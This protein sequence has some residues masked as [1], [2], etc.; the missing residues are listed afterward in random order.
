MEEKNNQQQEE[1]ELIRETIKTRPINRKKLFRRTVITA[2]MAVIF[3]VLACITFLVLEPVFSNLLSPKEEQP[4]PEVVE[5][6]LEE[7]E[8]LPQD[9]IL[10]EETPSQSP[11]IIKEVGDTT[12]SIERYSRLYTEMYDI[13]RNVKR[14]IVTVTGV[15]EDT[16]W[17][18]NTYERKGQT[19]GMIVA[20]NSIEQLILTDYATISNSE[21]IRVTYFNDLTVEATIKGSDK[22]TGLAIVAVKNSILPSTLLD[23]K[24]IANLGSSRSSS[25]LGLPII[26]VGRPLGNIDSIEYGMITSKSSVLNMVDNNYELMTTDLHGNASSTGVIYNL[27]SEVVGII[28][29]KGPADS[30]IISVLGISDIKKTIERMSNGK[31]RAYL[32]VIGTDVTAYAASQGIPQG[33]YVTSVE[34]NSPALKAGIQ[35]GDVITQV[36]SYEISTYSNFTEAITVHEPEEEASITVRR[37]GVDGYRDVTITVVLDELR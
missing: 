3:G 6:P 2:A 27:S 4:V 28:Y 16:D 31:P 13:S 34:M 20:N 17:F 35:S 15:N 24:I 12:S 21:N 9:M 10:E 11:I 18:N 1:Y 25:L 22:N 8:V 30:S 33:A 29:Q 26:A 23:E 19:T 36:D 7:D 14:S 37:Y 5:I 32:G